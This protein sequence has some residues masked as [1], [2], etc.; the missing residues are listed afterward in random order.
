MG[1]SF[2]GNKFLQPAGMV[3][4]IAL[5]I[6]GN[7][8]LFLSLD[9]KHPERYYRFELRC[10]NLPIPVFIVPSSDSKDSILVRGATTDPDGQYPL[11]DIRCGKTPD[12][13]NG[14]RRGNKV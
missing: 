10:R 14:I 11:Y 13:T 12:E 7:I 1:I 4:W 9:C 6:A 5:L 8:P 2:V 3:R